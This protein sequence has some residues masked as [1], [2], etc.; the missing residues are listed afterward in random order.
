MNLSKWDPIVYQLAAVFS[1]S[2]AALQKVS[3]GIFSLTINYCKWLMDQNNINFKCDTKNGNWYIRRGLSGHSKSTFVEEGKGG[4]S[5][6]VRSFLKKMLRFSKWSF[7]VILEFFL[8]IVM[9]VWN[10]QQT[11]MEDYNIQSCQWMTYDRFQQ[12]FLLCTTFRSFLYTV[13]YFLCVFSA[14]MAP[15]SLDIDNVCFVIRG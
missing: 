5:L 11:I 3:I 8:L 15:Y 12:P 14:K 4:G 2:F 6:R 10:I 13:H 7:I 9:A 1:L